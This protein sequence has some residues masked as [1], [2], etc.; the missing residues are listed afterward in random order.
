MPVGCTATN[1]Q[2]TW[3]QNLIKRGNLWAKGSPVDWRG[4]LWW[5]RGPHV[6]FRV[7]GLGF[8]VRV[9]VRVRV[10]VR[11]GVGVKVRVRV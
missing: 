8:R 2:F 11:V 5:C 9:S 1:P 3:G 10:R 6:L 7:L 4:V